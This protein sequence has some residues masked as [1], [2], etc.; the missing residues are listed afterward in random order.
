MPLATTRVAAA[1]D[2]MVNGKKGKTD[3]NAIIAMKREDCD[4]AGS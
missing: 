3:Q 2:N 1:R 4:G